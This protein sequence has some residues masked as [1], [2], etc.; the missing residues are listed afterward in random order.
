MHENKNRTLVGDIRMPI[1][2][3]LK[4]LLLKTRSLPTARFPD[5]TVLWDVAPET[6]NDTNHLIIIPPEW[7]R[8][9]LLRGILLQDSGNL[10]VWYAAPSFLLTPFRIFYLE[11]MAGAADTTVM[12]LREGEKPEGRIVIW[13][14]EVLHDHLA[15]LGSL[16]APGLV[17]FDEAEYLGHPEVGPEM[18]AMLIS[19]PSNIPTAV[20]VSA[21]TNPQK[22]A[23]GLE[24]ARGRPCRL[25]EPYLQPIPIVPAFLS[26]QWELIPLVEK[27]HL[28]GR[29]KRLTKEADPFPSLRSHFIQQLAGLLREEDLTPA[30]L[31]LPSEMDCDAAATACTQV[32][33]N[34]GEVLTDPQISAILDRHSFL[35]SHPLLSGAISRKAAPLHSDHHPLWCTLVEHLM[36]LSKIDIIF[37]TADA[38][39]TLMSGMRTVVMC[40]SGHEQDDGLRRR[41]I[42][43]WEMSGIK[44]A[45]GRK[46]TEDPG[47]FIVVHAADVDVVHLKDVFFQNPQALPGAFPC[48]CR[49]V[50]PLLTHDA[51]PMELLER[52]FSAEPIS[53]DEEARFRQ[54]TE[55]LLAELP[56]AR[57]TPYA[58]SVTA[59]IAIRRRLTLSISEAAANLKKSLSP[60]RKALAEEE[61][62][63]LESTIALLPCEECP[64][65]S[66]CHKRGFRKFRNLLEEYDALAARA[67]KGIVGL[68]ADCGHILACL[69]DFELAGKGRELTKTGELALRTGLEAPQLLTECIRSRCFPNDPLHSFALAGG[70]IECAE[71][72]LPPAA[73][74]LHDPIEELLPD[75]RVME[76]IL[77]RTAQRLLRFGILA[78]RFSLTQS[79]ALLALKKGKSPEALTQELPIS[80]G[81]L[82]RLLERAEYLW[83]RI[84][85]SII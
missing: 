26:S 65:F 70:F 59:L 52:S 45:L 30:L 79:A 76:P 62:H 69:R 14:L 64:H 3:K 15:D 9:S 50:L 75:Y 42:G 25:H 24:K 78:P 44:R 37:T 81:A 43:A 55:E 35:K 66:L 10:P 47:C 12:P 85:S 4:K 6:L 84:A 32:V 41:R 68:R 21:A 34:V 23:A 16:P 29:V 8:T 72:D 18:E 46:K 22:L 2:S 28:T 5:E 17:V 74:I 82:I 48:N 60:R 38:A 83:D 7:D 27:K 57:C 71:C 13:S 58:Q 80:M 77:T 31:V 39:Q 67:R 73:E 11:S 33:R 53:E 61:I 54:I 56:E 51:G 40:A 36:M 63:R 1:D 19:L 20:L 49:N